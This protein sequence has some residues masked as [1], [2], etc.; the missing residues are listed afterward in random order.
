MRIDSQIQLNRT[1]IDYHQVLQKY[2]ISSEGPARR[3][4]TQ[5]ADKVLKGITW[6]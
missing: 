6:T 2:Q 5:V 3:M 1:N 4:V